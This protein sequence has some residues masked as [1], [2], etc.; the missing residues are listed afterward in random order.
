MTESEIRSLIDSSQEEG[1]RALFQQYQSYVYAIVWRRIC[2]VGTKEDA[3]E[4]VSDVFTEV[5]LHYDEI[6]PGSLQGFLAT[7]ANRRAVDC[8]R[9]HTAQKSQFT[10][11]A[12]TIPEQASDED[13]EAQSDA[14]SL[15]RFLHE[16]ILA[17]GEPDST[18]I[19]HKYFYERSTSEIAASLKLSPVNVR[20]RMSRAL[21][22]LRTLLAEKEI[23]F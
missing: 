16:Q 12:D 7:V 8:F 1:F 2:A 4:C 6:E 14:K 22:R 21:K 13:I 10:I 17:L 23:Y 11:D 9:R 20:V 19:L 3:E 18:I 5:F 15:S